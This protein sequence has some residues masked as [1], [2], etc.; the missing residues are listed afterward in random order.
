MHISSVRLKAVPVAVAVLLGGLWSTSQ[1]LPVSYGNITLDAAYHLGG[2]YS[3]GTPPSGV[4]DGM[5]DPAANIFS[6][7]SGADVLLFSSDSSG[8]NAFFHTYG[9]TGAYT[10]FGARAS[11]VGDF[12]ASTR[13]TFSQTF[14][15]TSSSAQLFNFSF[16]IANGE[17]GISGQGAGFADLL[18]NIKR[19]GSTVARSRTT[20]TQT[21]GGAVSCDDS[22][23][24]QGSLTNYMNCASPNGA[25]A[26]D[27]GGPFAV[28]M[29][30]VGAGESFVLDY[31]IIATVSGNLSQG[32]RLEERCTGGYGGYGDV[33]TLLSVIDSN[34]Y[35]GGGGGRRAS[36]SRCR[37]LAKPS[38]ARVTRSAR[39]SSS[40][41]WSSTTRDQPVF[42]AASMTCRSQG[43]SPL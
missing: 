8:N 22:S 9:F 11:G 39:R 28:N 25:F 6:T 27:L 3:G 15:N 18:L 40:T 19:N 30:L 1:A 5:A 21:S 29:G 17:L 38:P 20:I 33:A 43:R 4:V 14:T 37:C 32:T 16:N 12:Y 42:K 7:P 26:T 31:D 36:S 13:A 34:S 10:Y 35:G 24:D 23:S 2:T 41:T